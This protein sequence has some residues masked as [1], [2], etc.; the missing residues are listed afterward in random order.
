MATFGELIA[1]VQVRLGEV[2]GTAADL[3][4]EE[5]LGAYVQDAFDFVFD[6][7]WVPEYMVYLERTLDGSTGVI[8]AD[9]ADTTQDEY[10]ARFKDIRSVMPD[11]SD[12]NLA[13]LPTR[14]NPFR[15]VG[16]YP[17]YI[18]PRAGNR[19]FKIWPVEATGDLHIIGRQRP[20]EFGLDDEIYI[21]RLLLVWGACWLA[22]ES[23]STAPGHSEMFKNLF[24]ARFSDEKANFSNL[25]LELASHSTNIPTQWEEDR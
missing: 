14:I 22:S 12:K 2:Q 21:D 6:K 15:L 5:I 7:L 10:I 23:D 9:I 13:L 11:G 18:S 25:P 19:L 3:Y 4:S 24:D 17:R 20:E 16:T 8:T 1:Q